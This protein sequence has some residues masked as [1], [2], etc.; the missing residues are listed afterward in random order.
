MAV[1]LVDRPDQDGL[2]IH[3]H[4]VPLLGGLGVLAAVLVAAIRAWPPAA[5][6]T[7]FGVAFLTGSL[8]DARALR[9]WTRLVLL[10]AAGVLVAVGGARVWPGGTVGAVGV[11]LLVVVC[12]N[13]VNIVDGLDGLAGGLA[14]LAALAL[15]LV[16]V[17]EGRPGQAAL[18]FA[19]CGA[20]AGFLTWNRPPARIF[21][22]NGGAYAVGAMLG[23]LAAG[24]SAMDGSRGVFVSLIALAVFAAELVVTVVRRVLSRAPL[25]GGDRL[26]LYDRLALRASSRPVAT[27]LFWGMGALAGGLAFLLSLAPSVV[28]AAAAGVVLAA[29]IGEGIRSRNRGSPRLR[30][31][32]GE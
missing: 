32:A 3:R 7:G 20:L 1:G 30:E 9:P 2:K 31:R 22:G 14:A 11:V 16:L 23:A 24:V 10:M 15:A 19:L 26:H 25:A 28:A 8:D 6:V 21:L 17:H 29:A 13:A 5:V 18:G 12:A 4:P 27:V